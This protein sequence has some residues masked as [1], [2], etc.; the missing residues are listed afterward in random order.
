[1][2]QGEVSSMKKSW[3]VA[4]FCLA[5]ATSL[6]SLSSDHLDALVAQARY[7]VQSADAVKGSDE[8]SKL[9]RE[10]QSVVATLTAYGAH[11]ND[12]YGSWAKTLSKHGESADKFRRGELAIAKQ[13]QA[14]DAQVQSRVATLDAA[15]QAESAAK[16]SGAYAGVAVQKAQ[17]AARQAS[18]ASA[19]DMASAMRDSSVGSL[20]NQQ[21]AADT[22]ARSVRNQ[23][24][25]T[26]TSADAGSAAPTASV[27]A[28]SASTTAV[29][30]AS[31]AMWEAGN[32]ALQ[33]KI[34]AG[35]AQF[36]GKLNNWA[37]SPV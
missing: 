37:G 26:G 35:Q 23:T 29:S 31:Q 33:S 7:L 15:R 11:V 13:I 17:V 14:L 6:W 24:S 30:P 10:A 2:L 22:L 18:F 21:A 28:S 20:Q 12:Q 8:K 1:M 3:V 4:A 5:K 9:L 32:G 27:P 34:R 36:K 16:V 25:W 19:A